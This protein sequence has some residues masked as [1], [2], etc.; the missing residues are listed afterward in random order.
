MNNCYYRLNIDVSNALKPDWKHQCGTFD[1][2]GKYG[3]WQP[4]SNLI[5]NQEWLD[6]MKSIGLPIVN[7]MIFYRG[8]YAHTVDAH[9][10]VST[11][12]PFRTHNFGI[13]WCVGGKGSEMLWYELPPNAEQKVT[14]TRAKTPY[15]S[16]PLKELTEVERCHIGKQVT[17]VKTG[18]PHAIVMGEEPRWCFSARTFIPNDIPWQEVVELMRSKNILIERHI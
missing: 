18:L 7:A 2:T 13:N 17:L 8:S 6:Y 5:F 11:A 16:W 9:I 15:V 1:V 4:P 3:V 12:Q 10:D 14:Y